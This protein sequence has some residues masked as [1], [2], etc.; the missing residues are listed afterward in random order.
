MIGEIASQY[1]LA[2]YSLL[3]EKDRLPCLEAM[4]EISLSLSKEK[5]FLRLLCSYSLSLE[6]KEKVIE[7]VYGKIAIPYLCDFLKLLCARH[8][9]GQYEEILEA[10]A[11][12]VHEANRIKEGI[13]YSASKLSAEQIKQIQAKLEALL[14]CKVSLKEEVDH[15]LLGGVK[16]ALDGK[17]YDGSLRSRL[18]DLQRT[19]K[20]PGGSSI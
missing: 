17:V 20:K 4:K 15:T 1:A 10:F 3:E 19:L 8:R 18:L 16:V 7:A 11:S 13:V 6:E 5:D 2:L 12:L 14:K 9:M